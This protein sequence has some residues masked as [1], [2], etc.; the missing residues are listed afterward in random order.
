[1][2]DV[3]RE[4]CYSQIAWVEKL[5][6]RVETQWLLGKE[7]DPGVAVNDE[8]YAD[9]LLGHEKTHGYWFSLKEVQL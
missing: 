3:Y 4:A 2:S 7:H 1:M 8:G 6:R 9:S 5:V